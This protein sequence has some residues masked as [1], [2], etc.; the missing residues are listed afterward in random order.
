MRAVRYLVCAAPKYLHSLEPPNNYKKLLPVEG[1]NSKYRNNVKRYLCNTRKTINEDKIIVDFQKALFAKKEI[2]IEI[3]D[4][5]EKI[6]K[7]EKNN[8]HKMRVCH[9][10]RELIF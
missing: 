8:L 4:A 10:G 6:I 3:I 7:N 9:G 1:Y 5:S 2:I